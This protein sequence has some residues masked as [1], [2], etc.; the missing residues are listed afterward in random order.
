MLSMTRFTVAETSTRTDDPEAETRPPRKSIGEVM[1]HGV[2]VWAGMFA[3]V[4]AV[5]SGLFAL[6]APG[7]WVDRVGVGVTAALLFLAACAVGG[8]VGFVFALPRA[9]FTDQTAPAADQEPVTESH[10]MANTNLL[11]VSDWLTTIL[12]GLGLVQLGR[13]VPAVG[14]L[15]SVLEEP[16]GGGANAGAFGVAVVVVSGIVGA[17]LTYLWTSVR[18]RELLEDSEERAIALRERRVALRARTKAVDESPGGGS[19]RGRRPAPPRRNWQ[20]ARRIGT[21]TNGAPR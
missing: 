1:Q 19:T 10:Y 16:L 17:V 15:A 11:K 2:V 18:V 21:R 6:S 13:V 8:I 12:I 4:G 20:P 14:N 9:R 3:A 7:R 5:A